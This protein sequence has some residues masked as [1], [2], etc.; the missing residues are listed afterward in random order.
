MYSVVKTIEKGTINIVAVP[1][2][3]VN[4]EKLSWPKQNIKI[5]RRDHQS[6]PENGWD[7]IDCTV[8][9]EGLG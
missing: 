9:D 7:R 2:S 1:S 5:L 4:D 6:K 8:L 3:W